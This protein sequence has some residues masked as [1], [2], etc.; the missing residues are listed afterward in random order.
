MHTIHL[1]F[2]TDMILFMHGNK[3]PKPPKPVNMK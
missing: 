3:T 1:R 2:I